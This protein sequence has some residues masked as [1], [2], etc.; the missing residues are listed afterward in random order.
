M[1]ILTDFNEIDK[2]IE[3]A[4]Q[5]DKTY[6]RTFTGK[7]VHILNP[8]PDEIDIDDIAHALSMI[9]R[10]TGHVSQFYSV[11]EHSLRVAKY[12][13]KPNK[14]WGLLHDA[15]EAYL[16]DIASPFKRSYPMVG[17]REIEDRFMSVIAVKYDLG[18][19][20]EEIDQIDKMIVLTEQKELTK[21][22]VTKPCYRPRPYGSPTYSPGEAAGRFRTM[23]DYYMEEKNDN[24]R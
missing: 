18:P 11:A 3:E 9:C 20:P 19:Y 5:E 12:A 1:S 23:F 24:V 21:S 17:Y 2:I 8:T 15:S 6:V 16:N 22:S 7:K 14:L 10:F 13:S 4:D